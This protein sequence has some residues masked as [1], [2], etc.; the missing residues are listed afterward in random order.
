ML[1]TALFVTTLR[2]ELT[3]EERL[4]RLEGAIARIEAR[5]NDTVSADELAPTL[6]EYSDLTRALGWDGKSSL[7][8]VKPAGKEK[9]LSLGGFVHANFE[10]GQVPDS[11]FTGLNNR[12]FLRR[13]RLNATGTYA[14]NISFKFEADFG[15][16]SLSAKTGVSAQLTDLY[17]S[18]T[19]LPTASLRLGQF[20][21]PFGY[22]Q[23]MADTK[24][25][26]VERSLPNDSLTL[27]RQIGLMLYGDAPNKR[28]SYSLGA[29]NG[30]GTNI[31]TNDNQKFLWVGRVS[32][33]ALDTKVGENK[34]KLTAG[35]DYFTTDDKGT[36]TG[37][38][39]GAS[40]DAQLAYGPAELQAE[41]LQNKRS[42][43]TGLATTANG[44]AVLGAYSFTPKWQ[45][46][47]RYENYDTNTAT[48]NTTTTLWTYGV[49]YFIKGD[50]LK[51]SFDY[52]SGQQ[53]TP[54][55]RG[56]RFITRLQIVF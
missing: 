35:V 12:F 39:E 50:D 9:S 28:L 16:N 52:L 41:W 23:L 17:I 45:G 14:E 54:A 21:T 18:W 55:P 11:R 25:M 43:L 51:L 38:R 36:F 49:N 34:V 7:N 19:K 40:V 24:I 10:S 6:K 3:L 37:R 44:W 46:V 5:L 30:T 13:A 47:L 2:A 31:S 48:L 26:T 4:T 1:V 22:E 15:A 32:A 56:N 42:P 33:V 27:G 8:A 20:K 29:Y 53:P